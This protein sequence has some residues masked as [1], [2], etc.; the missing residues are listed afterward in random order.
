MKEK[1]GNKLDIFNIAKDR[2]RNE[3]LERMKRQKKVPLKVKENI[4]H[5][6]VI[7]IDDDKSK[8][9]IK[10][11]NL[12][13]EKLKKL[14]PYLLGFVFFGDGRSDR[15]FIPAVSGISVLSFQK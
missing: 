7:E 15:V 4:E 11:T 14:R 8:Y 3:I 6:I 2:K 1:V 5:K 13:K 9:Y 10:Q 12:R